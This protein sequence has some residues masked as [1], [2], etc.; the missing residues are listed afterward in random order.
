MSRQRVVLWSLATVVGLASCANVIGIDGEYSEGPNG[1]GAMAGQGGVA[2]AGATTSSSSSTGGH[3]GSSSG[4]GGGGGGGTTNCAHPI[5]TIG[6]ALEASCDSCATAVCNAEADCCNTAWNYQCIEAV[7]DHCGIDCATSVISCA[8]QYAGA[9]SFHHCEQTSGRCFFQASTQSQSC[10]QLCT[11]RG[12]ECLDSYNNTNTCGVDWNDHLSC[13]GT[14]Y[15]SVI[16]ICSRGC[17]VAAPCS[18]PQT[19]SNGQCQ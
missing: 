3:A 17:G 4:G 15:N 11:E 6:A 19:C 10:T 8:D 12:G 2:G 1:S 16:C 5:C 9:P 13:D 14:G 18:S 7:D